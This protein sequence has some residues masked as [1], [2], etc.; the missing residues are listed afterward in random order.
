M[1]LE[2]I[3]AKDIINVTLKGSISIASIILGTI[4]NYEISSK[5]PE[6][7]NFIVGV[8][9]EAAVIVPAAYFAR[10]AVIIK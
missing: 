4:G 7:Y 1:G 5:L 2:D 8:I 3:T 10:K 6:P 9:H